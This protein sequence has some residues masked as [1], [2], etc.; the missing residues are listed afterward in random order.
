MSRWP[1]S[2]AAV[3]LCVTLA[4]AQQPP[5]ERP[6]FRT[7]VEI[8]HLD[9]SVLDRDRRPVRGLTADDFTVLED[10]RPQ[11]IVVFNAVDI[12]DPEPPPAGWMREVA[13]EV[14][15]NEGSQERRL[16]LI[17]IDDAMLQG[18][19]VLPRNVRDIGRRIVDRLGPSDLAAVVFT[20][21]NRNSQDYTSDRGRLLS[22]IDKADMRFRDMGVR[23]QDE[24]YTLYSVQVLHAAVETLSALPERRK[25][26]VYIGQGIPFGSSGVGLRS[27]LPERIFRTL[28]EL[29]RRA[30]AA[31]TN[32]YT[33]DVCGAR[34]PRLGPGPPICE[35]GPEEDYVRTVA[36]NTGGRAVVN[37]ND[38][39]PGVAA[40]FQENSS[41]Y[42]LGF[43]RADPALDGRRRRLE[44]RVNRPGVMIRTRDSYQA[45]RERDV[46]RRQRAEAS[47]PLRAAM[48]GILPASD[49]PLRAVAAPFAVPG[50]REAAV[51]IVVGV[52]QPVRDG[53]Q[54]ERV[55]LEVSAFN[56]DG[57]AFG[58]RRLRADV[59]PRAG[60]SGL[61]EYD[62]LARLDLRPGRY[63]L[64]I[65]AHVPAH[66]TSGSVYYDVDVPDFRGEALSLSG[67][68]LST[69]LG[70]IVAPRDAL[71]AVLPVVPTTLRTFTPAQQVTAF[72]RVHQGG[73]GALAVVPLR[74]RITGPGDGIVLER[75]ED[76]G[77]DRFGGDRGADIR[78][79]LPIRELESGEYLL[80]VETLDERHSIRRSS[81]FR[82]ALDGTGV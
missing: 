34:V 45:E 65:A 3:S 22:A 69:T 79:D 80:T 81:R 53:S 51:A 58:S 43:Q 31:N 6:Q 9:V 35:P 42:L 11:P 14:A 18:D 17:L 36:N 64:R 13:P 27:G 46:A 28:N 21:D 40:V 4:T 52:T 1:V 16:F 33:F 70:P 30:A 74:I 39:A 54:P 29:F 7:G 67:L 5:P 12:P 62:L 32:V 72:L 2:L 26:I 66:G 82:V 50:R 49:L 63:Q 37:T 41:Y 75:R 78:F 68:V 55:D 23:G 38:F 73:R 57:R 47:A 59:R 48:S 44:V 77:I 24:L 8:V 71:R 19:P 56:T 25:V 10:G 61:G 76:V 60:A 20:L 15:A